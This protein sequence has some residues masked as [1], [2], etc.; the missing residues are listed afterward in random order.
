MANPQRVRVRLCDDADIGI[1]TVLHPQHYFLFG[2]LRAP[3]RQVHSKAIITK[4]LKGALPP[5]S[6]MVRPQHS[7]GDPI[8]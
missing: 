6:Q 1:D 3:K 7:R 5:R 8:G 4:V 2:V